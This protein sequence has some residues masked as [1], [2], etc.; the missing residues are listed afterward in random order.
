MDIMK[1]PQTTL[2][3]SD[4]L[5]KTVDSYRNRDIN[6]MKLKELLYHYYEMH[7]KLIFDEHNNLLAT[8]KHYVGKRR[9]NFIA[10]VIGKNE[11]K[12]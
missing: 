9:L 5:N 4:C 1:Y 2:E 8:I 7:N 11:F 6:E 10:K 3:M 12:I